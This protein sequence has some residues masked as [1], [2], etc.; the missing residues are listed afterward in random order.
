TSARTMRAR[1]AT[2][3]SLKCLSRSPISRKS[4]STN[5]ADD[6]PRLIAS[7]PTTPVPANT[8]KIGRPGTASPRMLNSASRVR[9]GVG[10][11]LVSTRQVNIRPRS[12]PATMRICVRISSIPSRS[13]GVSASKTDRAIA[14]K[15][16]AP[17]NS[18]HIPD[19]PCPGGRMNAI[20]F[21]LSVM[22][23]LEFF[24]WGAWFPLIFGYLPSLGFDSLQQGLILG[25]FNVAALVALF[26]ST[27]FADRNF[28]AEKFLAFSQLVGGAAIMAL[29]WIRKPEGADSAPFWPFFALMLVHSLF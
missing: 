20:R 29:F 19:I 2:L 18:R 5:V 13:V 24:I 12:D 6:A 17:Y 1:S 23:F 8:S 15:G 9:C 4:R 21:K 28:A 7:R 27:Q 3:N 11:R 14:D 26:F 16:A 10:R 25:G 22:M